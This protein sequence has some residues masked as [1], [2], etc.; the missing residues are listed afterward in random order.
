MIRILVQLRACHDVWLWTRCEIPN[1][2]ILCKCIYTTYS[3]GKKA[4]KNVIAS[5]FGYH[6]DFECDF[7]L[8]LGFVEQRIQILILISANAMFI[9]LFYLFFTPF[10]W[11]ISLHN[12]MRCANISKPSA[13]KN[14]HVFFFSF[15]FLFIILLLY[16]KYM[17]TLCDYSIQRKL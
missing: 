6:I 4:H 17:R 12:W 9:I 7:D 16:M 3:H 13:A 2:I 10:L 11:F 5:Y 1:W 14:V 8:S 15:C